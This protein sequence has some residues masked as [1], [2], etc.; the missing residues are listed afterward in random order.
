MTDTDRTAVVKMRK[1]KMSVRTQRYRANEG[2]PADAARG[3]KAAANLLKVASDPV[4][5]TIL[6]SLVE[7]ECRII[8]LADSLEL[9]APTVSQHLGILS[10]SG[11]IAKHR[12]GSQLLYSLTAQGLGIAA[13][14]HTLL[15]DEILAAPK[16]S[17]TIP[18]ERK[19][20]EDVGGFVDDPEE[21]FHTP[22]A[23]FEGRQPIELLGTVDE[24]RL[25][26]RI[27]AA[28]L[29]MFS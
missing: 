5:L 3:A 19:L 24:S 29:G 14:V 16:A 8:E 25:R 26:N 12:H 21:W 15:R 18:I 11:L 9:D 20:L 27:E 2:G 4:R 22:N 28:K 1:F 10:S 6:M 13:V 23:A 7:G 17:S